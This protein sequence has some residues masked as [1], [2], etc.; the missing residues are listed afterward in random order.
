MK[1]V[2]LLFLCFGLHF[3]VLAQTES[4]C[5][6]GIDNDSDG[7]VDCFDSNCANDNACTNFYIG[8]DKLC[9]TPPSGTATFNLK[10]GAVSQDSATWTSG[11]IVVG[12][13]NRD[14][15]PEVVSIHQDNKRLNIFRGSDLKREA[16]GKIQGAAEYFDIAIGNIKN[17]N[18]GE[19]FFAEKE[20]SVYYISSYDCTGKRLWRVP[21]SGQPINFGLADF[22]QDGK[23]EIYYRNEILDAE[24]GMR[25]VKAGPTSWNSIDAGP[26]AVDILPDTEC[27]EC[28]GLELIIGGQI[29]AVKIVPGV[30]D[31]GSLGTAIKSIPAAAN[32][33]PKYSSVFT[34]VTS[35]TSVADF[36]LDGNLDVLMSG[37][38]GSTTGTKTVFFLDV[39]GK[40]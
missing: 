18:C 32:Y 25:L 12:D 34:F 35:A 21:A 24:T 16:Y 9:Q 13:L 14:G 1:K 27:T 26:V 5:G 17:D 38:S 10:L 7:F 15:I 40:A 29:F 31:G 36:N 6:D 22:N 19:I 4:N 20:S 30:A 33:F 39:A 2:W 8:K 23:P 28:P 37:G 3:T 11:K